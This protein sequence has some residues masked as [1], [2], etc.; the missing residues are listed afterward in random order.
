MAGGGRRLAAR[1]GDGRG[2]M[3]NAGELVRQHGHYALKQPEGEVVI[4]P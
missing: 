4:I 1:A 2:G 3:L